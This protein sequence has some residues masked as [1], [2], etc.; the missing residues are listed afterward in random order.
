[1]KKYLLVC[2]LFI[3]FQFSCA[4][5]TV[6][7]RKSIPSECPPTEFAFSQPT[8]N[9]FTIIESNR[10]LSNKGVTGSLRL[11]YN[12]AL[13]SVKNSN[14]LEAL[15]LFGELKNTESSRAATYNNMGV[16]YELMNDRIKALEMYSKACLLD[17]CV[18]FKKNYFACL[19]GKP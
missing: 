5:S 4:D 19:Y 7:L 13:D 6:V 3:F 11:I 16:V 2:S 12:Y 8:N 15:V 1:M 10:Y 18:Y 17:D 9:C 14:Y